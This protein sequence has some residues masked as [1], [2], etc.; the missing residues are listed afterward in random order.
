MTSL[1]LNINIILTIF[2]FYILQTQK[3]YLI[4]MISGKK[5]EKTSRSITKTEKNKN[6]WYYSLQNYEKTLFLKYNI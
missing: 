5:F 4:I 6:N 1:N 3:L 2:A